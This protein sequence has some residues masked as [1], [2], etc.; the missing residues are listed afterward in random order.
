MRRHPL[1]SCLS[2]YKQIF[3]FDDRYY[4]YVYDLARRRGSFVQFDRA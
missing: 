3:P 2:N 4:D 1:D